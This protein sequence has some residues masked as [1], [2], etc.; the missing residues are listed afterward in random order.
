M[1]YIIY[2]I[3]ILLIALIPNLNKNNKVQLSIL[4]N[5]TVSKILIL[6]F[7]LFSSLEDI[8]LGLLTILLYFTILLNKSE[9]I[10]GYQNYFSV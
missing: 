10:E 4:I 6:L 2:I 9:S 7:I 1:I 8:P 3:I 5:N